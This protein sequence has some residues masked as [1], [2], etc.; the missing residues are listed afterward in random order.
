MCHLSYMK[1]KLG[2]IDWEQSYLFIRQE[3]SKRKI[4]KLKKYVNFQKPIT[5]P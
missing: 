4:D 3:V 5:S 2:F 1:L